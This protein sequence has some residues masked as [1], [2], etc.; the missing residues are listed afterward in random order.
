[1]RNDGRRVR[2]QLAREFLWGTVPSQR[3]EMSNI[4]GLEM[5]V[6]KMEEQ[7]DE[8]NEQ[9]PLWHSTHECTQQVSTA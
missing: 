9:A 4:V 1:M 7:A 8:P 2:E 6:L 3:W 5:S